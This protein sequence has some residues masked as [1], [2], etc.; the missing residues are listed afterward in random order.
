METQIIFQERYNIFEHIEC[1]CSSFL[2]S[3]LSLFRLL[4]QHSLLWPTHFRLVTLLSS[5]FK[6]LLHMQ[7]ISCYFTWESA[8]SFVF[9]YYCYVMCLM[10]SL[11]LFNELGEFMCFCIG[12]LFGGIDVRLFSVGNFVWG[13]L[14]LM[15]KFSYFEVWIRVICIYI[16]GLTLT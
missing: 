14:I 12:L 4:S 6:T 2:S 9:K 1:V 5:V 15:C 11:L 16:Y 7:K 3:G 8:K 13:M 10:V